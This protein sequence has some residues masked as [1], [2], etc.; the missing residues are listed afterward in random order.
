MKTGTDTESMAD[1]SVVLTLTELVASVLK[2]GQGAATV[3][4]IP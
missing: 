4:E 1:S 2:I 3:V